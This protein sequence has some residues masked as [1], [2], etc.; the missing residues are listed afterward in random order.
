MRNMKYSPEAKFRSFFIHR[1][2]SFS[3]CTLQTYDFVS[4][5]A[6]AQKKQ[7]VV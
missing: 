2:I 7:M 3:N 6:G 4:L 1:H 5:G